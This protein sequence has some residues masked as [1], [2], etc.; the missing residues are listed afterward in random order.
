[1]AMTFTSLTADKITAGS[2]RRWVNYAPLD[3]EQVLEEAQALIYQTLR[4]REMRTEFPPLTLAPGEFSVSLPERFLDP[5]SLQNTTH[6]LTIDLTDETSISRRRIFE[7]GGLIR[8]IP[9]YYAI[10]GEAMQFDCAADEGMTL[11]L[12]G[13]QRPEYLS[14]DNPSNFL[15]DRYPNLLRVA[16]L[17]QAYDFMSNTAKYQSN[18]S[19]LSG[20]IASIA[21]QDDLSLRGGVFETRI[22]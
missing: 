7:D 3:V 1:M 21:A 8:S 11:S 9:R 17:T 12:I 22:E 4:V 6:N 14:A 5:V 13:F 16:C 15:T 18:L 19:L 10:F 2:I 20:L